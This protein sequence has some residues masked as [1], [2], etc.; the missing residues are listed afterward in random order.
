[1]EVVC[2]ENGPALIGRDRHGEPDLVTAGAE[3]T[4]LD[5]QRPHAVGWAVCCECGDFW[6]V[7]VDARADFDHLECRKGCGMTAALQADKPELAQVLPFRSEA[8]PC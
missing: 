2:D 7:V 3:V 5:S 4:N 8:R 6:V 1:M